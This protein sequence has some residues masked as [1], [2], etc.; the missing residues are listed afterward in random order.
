MPPKLEIVARS[1]K[2]TCARHGLGW[3]R[4]SDTC[5][6]CP[7]MQVSSLGSSL[8]SSLDPLQCYDALREQ[9]PDAEGDCACA[10]GT[11]PLRWHFSLSALFCR[12]CPAGSRKHHIGSSPCRKPVH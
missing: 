11:Q 4:K 8:G 12:Q 5:V 6:P 10:P 9:V 3:E 2:E 7:R 1:A